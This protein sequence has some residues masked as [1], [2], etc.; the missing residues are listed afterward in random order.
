[1][2]MFETKSCEDL[3][4]NLTWAQCIGFKLLNTE[5]TIMI[6]WKMWIINI[7]INHNCRVGI[8]KGCQSINSE[9][10][11]RSGCYRFKMELK[12]TINRLFFLKESCGKQ[13]CLLLKEASPTLFLLRRRKEKFTQLNICRLTSTLC[14][15]F[16][17]LNICRLTSTL[18]KNKKGRTLCF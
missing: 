5:I 16:T 2:K 13:I 9:D 17:Q 11:Y 8:W 12:D 3:F 4:W 1:M 7:V 18:C 15:K 10:G 6:K 14:T